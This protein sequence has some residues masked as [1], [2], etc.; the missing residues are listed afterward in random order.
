MTRY[1]AFATKG[2]ED[3]AAAELADTLADRLDWLRPGTKHVLFATT[4]TPPPAGSLSTTAD[5]S[6]SGAAHSDAVILRHLTTVDDVCVVAAE[7]STVSTADDLRKL[8]AAIA[9]AVDAIRPLR[10]VDD[11]FSVTVT[12]ARTSLGTSADIA[13]VVA[14][15]LARA[16]AG[17]CEKRLGHRWTYVYF[18]MAV[19]PCSGCACSSGHCPIGTI[20]PSTGLARCAPPWP[21]PWSDWP[22]PTAPRTTCGILSA[23]RARSWPRR[24]RP[25]I[26][27]AAATSTRTAVT[28]TQANLGPGVEVEVADAASPTTW[29]RHNTVD[30]VLANLPWGKQI[31]LTAA[32]SLYAQV[33]VGVA[34]LAARG[35]R[36]SLLTTEPDRL[37]AAIRR[38]SPSLFVSR[39]R[40]G[41]LG[42]TPTLL[43]IG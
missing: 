26:T 1:V 38:A 25:D 37:A 43:T 14:D 15:A 19:P 21:R 20:G 35:G 33:G 28:V 6:A 27:Y 16:F 30:T 39:R 7:S 4:S 9:P 41:L 11:T 17:T 22:G 5:S 18:W 29:Y 34:Q 32:A 31:S 3:V 10:G 12:A 8:L 40:L 23:V 36:A 13:G 24:A 2:L 42:Q